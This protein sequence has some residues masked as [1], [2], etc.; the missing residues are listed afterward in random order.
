VT[1]VAE[2]ERLAFDN[3]VTE[4]FD[5]SLVLCRPNAAPGARDAR[6]RPTA[7]GVPTRALLSRPVGRKD[8][9]LG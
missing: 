9:A 7:V 8:E 2:T 6:L 5:P 1:A 3:L 4:R